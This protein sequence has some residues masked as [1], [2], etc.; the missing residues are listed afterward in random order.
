MIKCTGCGVVL[1]DKD[2][3]NI[4]YTKD[5]NHKLC[6]RCFKIKNYNEYTSILKNNDEY[7]SIL[8]EINKTDDLVLLVVD[9]FD[10]PKKL[11]D[12]RNII[13]NDILLVITKRDILPLSVY[14]NNLIDYFNKYN[15]NPVDINLIS[16]KKIIILMNYIII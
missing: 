1:Q 10:I 2:E 9:V 13:K 12:I 6:L 11:S 8:K 14:D 16:S 7:L 3:N 4:G 5:I 15:I